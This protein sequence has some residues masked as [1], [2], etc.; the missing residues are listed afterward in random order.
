[1]MISSVVS[2]S[3]D[4]YHVES[5]E[6]SFLRQYSTSRVTAAVPEDRRTA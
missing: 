6:T 2:F 4:D 5:A 1:M 3:T